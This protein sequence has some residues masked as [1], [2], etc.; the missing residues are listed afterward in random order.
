MATSDRRDLAEVYSRVRARPK[1]GRLHEAAIQTVYEHILHSGD[2]AIDGGAHAGKHTVPLSRAV[3]DHGRVLAFEPSPLPFAKLSD[4]L[5][6]TGASNVSPYR[7]A[8]SD[9]ADRNVTFLVFPDRPG[10]SGFERRTDQAGELPAEEITVRT[11]TIDEFYPILSS[12]RFVKLDVEGAELK[13]L[14]GARQ[15]IEQFH[16]IVHIEASFISWDAFGYGPAELMT[17]C[18]DFGYEVVDIVGLRLGDEEAIAES[19]NTAGVWDY[20]LLPKGEVQAL[21]VLRS[22]AREHYGI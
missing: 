10:V 17:Y 8:L 2:M 22:H 9:V 3:G 4:R 13:A 14:W 18:E 12:L 16:P 20:L 7:L 6:E 21:D 11:T 1:H 5:D 19:F 15:T